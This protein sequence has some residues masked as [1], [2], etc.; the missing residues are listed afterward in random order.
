M[1]GRSRRKATGNAMSSSAAS[2]ASKPAQPPLFTDE[3]TGSPA[4]TAGSGSTCSES[5]A[6]LPP[7]PSLLK[8]PRR[9]GS[10]RCRA[11]WRALAMQYPD[12]RRRLAALVH[13]I[14]AGGCSLLPTLTARDWKP[15]GRPDHPRLSASRGEP[16]PETLGCRLSVQFCEWMMGFPVNWTDVSE[17][18]PSETP[19]CPRS[20]SGLP[21]DS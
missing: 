4:P 6:P 10:V 20:P 1:S 5:S 16:L 9:R 17:L 19:S 18:P 15:P 12:L 21:A 7:A 11:A 3:G 2:P 8:T 13:L 14:D